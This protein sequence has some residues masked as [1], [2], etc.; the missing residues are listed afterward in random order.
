MAHERTSQL[1]HLGGWKQEGVTKGACQKASKPRISTL[2][3]PNLSPR[4][5]KMSTLSHIKGRSEIHLA[6]DNQEGQDVKE[7][8]TLLRH[9]PW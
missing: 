2:S 1:Q 7:I 5:L 8:G 4:N 3:T 6:G 9:S